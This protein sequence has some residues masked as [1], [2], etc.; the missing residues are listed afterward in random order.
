MQ[1]LRHFIDGDFVESLGQETLPKHNPANGQELAVVPLGSDSD[2]DRAV[3]CASTAFESWRLV[4]AV[5]RAR[6]LFRYKTLIDEHSEELSQ[7][8][9][10]EHGKALSESRGSVKRGIENV[11]R[12]CGVPSLMLGESAEDIAQGIDTSTFRQPMGVF[13]AIAPYNF[14]AMIP[15]WF[16]PYAL[17]TGNTFVLKPSEK[18]PLS[19]ELQMR[20]IQKAGFPKGV[21]NMVHGGR[22]VVS[23]LL[24]HEKVQGISFVG[25]TPVAK[26]IYEQSARKGKRVQALGGAKNHAVIMPDCKVD[27][28]VS[29]VVESA[30][31]CAGQ[32]CLAAS[33][34]IMVGEAYEH[35]VPRLVA[36]ARALRMGDGLEPATD[37]GPLISPEQKERVLNFIDQGVKDGAELLLDGRDAPTSHLRGGHFLGASV[38]TNVKTSMSI[39]REEIFGPV[40]CIARADNL[41]HA[42][43]MIKACPLANATSIFTRSGA[44]ARRF[45]H[46]VGVSMI[47]VN[48]GVAAPMAFFPFGGTKNSFFGDTKAHGNDAIRF[49]TDTK[50][51]ISRWF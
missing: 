46:D 41:D 5:E 27:E 32:R 38:F 23:S 33:V 28:T 12:A 39:L 21:I 20:L 17:M 49:Y 22:E 7:I 26:I 50:V 6:L 43:S 1:A 25:S 48:I 36:A 15:M 16:W 30:F 19:S 51:V 3:V 18:V 13:S 10:R 31:G 2:V 34:V 47:G 45:K 42:I 40:L 37:L 9:T 14:P 44:A 35:T 11:E 29:A 24:D 4:P 8:V